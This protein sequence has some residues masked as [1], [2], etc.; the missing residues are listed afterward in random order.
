V[1]G[2]LEVESLGDDLRAGLDARPEE[3][4]FELIGVDLQESSSD[5]KLA[6]VLEDGGVRRA[7]SERQIRKMEDAGHDAENRINVFLREAHDLHRLAGV[8]ELL[9]IV[10]ARNVHAARTGKV[11]K[12][13]GRTKGVLLLHL[14]AGAS[15]QLVEDVEA[16]LTLRLPNDTIPLEQV[17]IDVGTADDA[18]SI[19]L[20][21]DELAKTR[22]VVVTKGLGVTKGL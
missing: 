11:P 9:A 10:D 13:L 21:A 5:V 4:V 16:A 20:D 19:E 14:D 3:S 1:E 18:T 2:L 17:G 22:R 8:G 12:G 6:L 15:A 7:G